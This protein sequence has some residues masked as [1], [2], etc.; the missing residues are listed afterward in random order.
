M[1]NCELVFDFFLIQY[2]CFWQF[3]YFVTLIIVFSDWHGG[4]TNKALSAFH[5]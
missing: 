2:L 5:T 1:I 3:L 4:G